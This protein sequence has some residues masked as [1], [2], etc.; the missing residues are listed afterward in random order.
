MLFLSLKVL[1]SKKWEHSI[2]REM[3]LFSL[4]KKRLREDLSKVYK[5]LMAGSKENRAALFSRHPG[6]D[7]R[8]WDINWNTRNCEDGQALAQVAHISC[9]ISILGGI[10]IPTGCSEGKCSVPL[11]GRCGKRVLVVTELLEVLS[12]SVIVWFEVWLVSCCLRIIFLVTNSS[13]KKTLQYLLM[14]AS[15]SSLSLMCQPFTSVWVCLSHRNLVVRNKPT[16]GTSVF[17]EVDVNI[18][19]WA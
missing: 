11:L 3:G 19:L 1:L 4:K 9:G 6:Q 5:Y 10:H 14:Q 15:H 8:Q 7:E 12:V 13:H 2:L 18:F 16:S 17:P